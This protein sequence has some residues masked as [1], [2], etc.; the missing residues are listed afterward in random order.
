M[1]CTTALMTR[2]Y[3]G[4]T[5]SLQLRRSALLQMR[6]PRPGPSCPALAFQLRG[7]P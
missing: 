1:L 2:P 7:L 5:G 6:V 4:F 3:R